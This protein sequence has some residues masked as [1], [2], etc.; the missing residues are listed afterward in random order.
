VNLRH[1][2]AI[3]REHGAARWIRR[4]FLKQEVGAGLPS[5]WLREDDAGK[6]DV[7]MLFA[8]DLYWGKKRREI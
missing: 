1:A 3:H 6:G 2:E 7:V 4:M 8:D 5:Q